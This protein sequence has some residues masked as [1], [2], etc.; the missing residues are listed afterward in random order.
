MHKYTLSADTEEPERPSE[1]EESY[2]ES[3]KFRG[4]GDDCYGVVNINLH[5]VRLSV[6]ACVKNA[7]STPTDK[8]KDDAP[9]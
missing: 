3:P 6:C 8:A 4:A 1:H 5:A 2:L 7:E 9:R